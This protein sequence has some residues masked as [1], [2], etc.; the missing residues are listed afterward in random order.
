MWARV[1]DSLLCKSVCDYSALNFDS[2]SRAADN[3]SWVRSNFGK[4]VLVAKLAEGGMAEIFLA[5]EDM[6]RAGRRF[7]I[8]KRIRDAFRADPDYEDYFLTEGRVALQLSHPHLP[9]AYE[10]G[11]IDSALYLAME[12]IRG[13]TLLDILRNAYNARKPLS[14]R[15]CVTIA[16]AV[17]AALDHAHTLRDVNGEPLHIIHRDVTPQNTLVC[18]DGSIKLIDFGIAQARIQ[19]HETAA[20]VVKGKFSYLAPEQI[21]PAGVIDQRADLFSLG[22][23]MHES[24]LGRV[25]FRGRTDRETIKRVLKAP[26]PDPAAKR[27]EVPADLAKVVLRALARNP[28]NRYRSA[29]ALLADLEAVA[30]RENLGVSLTELR[31]EVRA[32]CG[33]PQQFKIPTIDDGEAPIERS[34]RMKTVQSPAR[35]ADGSEPTPEPTPSPTGLAADEDLRYFLARAGVVV[36]SPRPRRLSTTRTEVE[37]AELLATLER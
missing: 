11:E 8:I 32:L 37:F 10:L 17:A 29:A 2:A 4:Y 27:P 9:M 18:Y 31:E 25:L 7:V 26:I 35:R 36:P 34:R 6:G 16:R 20:G 19:S 24:L 22:V 21:D 3:G 23:M 30:D 5:V 28:V 13:P 33:P 12:F 1:A 14:V 15:S